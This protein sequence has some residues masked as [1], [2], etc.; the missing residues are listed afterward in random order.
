MSEGVDPAYMHMSGGTTRIAHREMIGRIYYTSPANTDQSY[1]FHVNPGDSTTFPWLHTVASN[2][3]EYSMKGMAF[4][5]KSLVNQFFSPTEMAAGQAI[6]A[7][8]YNSARPTF[9][10]NP[11]SSAS[12]M[13]NTQ[14][15]TIAKL[16]SNLYHAIECDPSQNP[17]ASQWVR[18]TTQLPANTDSRLYD[19]CKTQLMINSPVGG[20]VATPVLVGEMWAT[21]D[22]ELRKPL[23]APNSDVHSDFTDIAPKMGQ[24]NIL[25]GP[26]ADFVGSSLNVL[27]Y[28]D[29]TV[30][31]P[32]S[33]DYG[34]YLVNVLGYKG[35]GAVVGFVG[36]GPL[37]NN[38]QVVTIQ[39]GLNSYWELTSGFYTMITVMIKVTAANAYFKF[40]DFAAPLDT[41]YQ[42]VQFMITA[43]DSDIPFP[44]NVA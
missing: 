14:Y 19:M 6:I 4:Y 31:F 13:E 17:V 9:L 27:I 38:C 41:D 3:Q 5:Y 10:E 8:D 40:P 35:A 25:S 36:G 42:A 22:V 39:T 15:T 1:L 33:L 37:V 34:T 11:F 26:K 21:Y 29:G 44:Q 24:P 32:T 2:F 20:S 28:A 23:F 16:Q 30:K 18:T 7:T 43:V 12:E